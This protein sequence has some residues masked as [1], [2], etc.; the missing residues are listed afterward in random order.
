VTYLV[1]NAAGTVVRGPASLGSQAAGSH[2]FVWNGL[3]NGGARATSGTYRLELVT[4]RATSAGTLRGSATAPVR[5]DLAAPTMSSITGS[6]SGFYPY[7]DAYRD[8]FSPAFTLDEAAGMTLTVRN[9]S[10]TV[11]RTVSGSRGAGRTTMAWNGR[12]SAGY[13]VGAG[14]YYWTLT[15]QDAAGNRR[16]SARYTVTVS[17]KR[18]VT[19]STVVTKYGSQFSVAGGS[20]GGYCADA[21]PAMSDFAPYGVWLHNTCSLDWDGFQ[22]AGATYRFTAPAAFSYTS[23]RI[24]SYGNSLAPSR[25]GAG[26]TRWGTVDYTF[27][28]EIITGTSNAWRTIGSVSPAGLV[29]STRQVEATLYVPNA[30]YTNDYDIGQVRLVVTYKVLA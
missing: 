16:T 8:T 1:R 13:L 7:P 3:L 23:L 27:A 12:N 6:G 28:P 24:E 20:E 15:A 11:V 21:D 18:L 17:S 9:S 4:S 14:T 19:K 10:G 25:L 5:V 29:S 30:Y 22:I 2:T 26:F